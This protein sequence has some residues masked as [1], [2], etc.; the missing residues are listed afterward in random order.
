[1]S[2]R[3]APDAPPDAGGDEDYLH[4]LLPEGDRQHTHKMV[5]ALAAMARRFPNLRMTAEPQRITPFLLWG[6]KT[7]PMAWDVVG[8]AS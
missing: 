3:P 1:M 8:D 7:L 6:K 5:I 2:H 4:R